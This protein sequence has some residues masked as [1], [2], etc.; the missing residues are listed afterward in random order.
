MV[1][2]TLSAADSVESLASLFIGKDRV[3]NQAVGSRVVKQNGSLLV[4]DAMSSRAY[5]RKIN[6]IYVGVNYISSLK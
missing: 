6:N 1:L 5:T 2:M 3:M 4:L